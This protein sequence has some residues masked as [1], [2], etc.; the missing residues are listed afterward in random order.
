MGVHFKTWKCIACK[1]VLIWQNYCTMLELLEVFVL[2]VACV[3]ALLCPRLHI[4]P[5]A[6]FGVL[7]L[8]E[9]QEHLHK[10]CYHV[11]ASLCYDRARLAS[12]QH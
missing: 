1:V 8:D 5:P 7:R 2:Y 11:R 6:Y 12:K 3:F 10:V 4:I 9:I